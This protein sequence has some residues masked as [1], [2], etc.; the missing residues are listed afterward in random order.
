MNIPQREAFLTACSSF[1]PD[2]GTTVTKLMATWEE[3]SGEP[4]NLKIFFNNEKINKQAATPYG[5]CHHTES[6][7]KKNVVLALVLLFETREWE[8]GATSY[9]SGSLCFPSAGNCYSRFISENLLQGKGWK[10]FG[11][12][13]TYLPCVHDFYSFIHYYFFSNAHI[14]HYNTYVTIPYNVGMKTMYM[15][16]VFMV[17]FNSFAPIF[18]YIFSQ[19]LGWIIFFH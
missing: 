5:D 3:G 11:L 10:S 15:N 19:R 8:T 6:K 14:N 1:L 7:S 2:F 13:T 18:N 4:T 17:H 12:W 16:P 9:R